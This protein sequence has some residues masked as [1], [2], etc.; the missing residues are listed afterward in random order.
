[1][2]VALR[3]RKYV[4]WPSSA[5]LLV[6]VPV[7]PSASG[8]VCAWQCQAAGAAILSSTPTVASVVR[9]K[10]L[11]RWRCAVH[12]L[13]VPLQEAWT[14]LVCLPARVHPFASRGVKK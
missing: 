12:F 7:F 13:G 3:V 14:M 6:Y 8:N 10:E 9:P 4:H 1:M 2:G 5:M 11:G